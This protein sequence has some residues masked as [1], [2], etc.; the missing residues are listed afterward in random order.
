[1]PLALS[2]DLIVVVFFVT[3]LAYSFIVGKDASVK[4]IIASYIAIVA[5]QAIGALLD[6]GI[7]SSQSILVMLGFTADQHVAEIIKL[8][9]F[10]AAIIILSLQGGFE[11]EFEKEI[12]GVWD[13][14]LTAAFGFSTA[15]LLLTALLTYIAGRPLLDATLITAPLLQ[16]LLTESSLVRA[17]VEFQEIWFSLP[18]ILLIVVGFFQRR[19]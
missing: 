1:M 11:V 15:G 3:V 2:W 12:G 18:A 16:P 5:V 9:L 10:V 17:M 4:I 14:L 13:P 8:A 6:R 19:S 7:G